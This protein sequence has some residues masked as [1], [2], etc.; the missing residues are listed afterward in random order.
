MRDFGCLRPHRGSTR[1]TA[2]R[3]L[4]EGLEEL[5]TRLAP[6][7]VAVETPFTAKFPRAA[8]L[9]AEARGALLAELG[10]WGGDVVEYEPARVKAVV[11][12]LGN[13]DKQQVAYIVRHELSLAKIP[14]EDAADALAIA[15]CHLRLTAAT[16]VRP[17]PA[18]SRPGND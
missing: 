13:A 2:L 5:L 3:S 18:V 9:L 14:S 17:A 8:L 15:L 6:D 1:A 11:V 10:R 16:S 7:V 4:V 12:G